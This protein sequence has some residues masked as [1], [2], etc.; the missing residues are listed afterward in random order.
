[1]REPPIELVTRLYRD[2]LGRAPEPQ[3]LNQLLRVMAALN[4]QSSQALLAYFI[5][6]EHYVRL[7]EKIPAELRK[8]AEALLKEN[9]QL[10]EA[11]ARKLQAQTRAALAKA[12][13]ET[14]KEIAGNHAR[15]EKYS[16]FALMAVSLV[17]V[18]SMSGLTGYTLGVDSERRGGVVGLAPQVERMLNTPSGR[19]ALTLM[20]HNDLAYVLEQCA[21]PQERNGWGFTALGRPACR[22]GLWLEGP[23]APA[24][25]VQSRLTDALRA[26]WALSAGQFWWVLMIAGA[27][28]LR[29][30]QKVRHLRRLP[31]VGWIFDP[32]Q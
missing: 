16:K 2:L 23:P 26:L 8:Q 19:A 29:L 27:V 25:T 22:A 31:L 24:P 10:H 7:F 20:Q 32:D 6:Q 3:E 17:F 28:A 4:I 11:E 9:R 30:A 1:M 5:A 15:A 21:I 12:A 14:A 18:I 13:V